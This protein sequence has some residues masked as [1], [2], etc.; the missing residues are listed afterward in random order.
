MKAIAWDC[1]GMG[2]GLG[3]D[4]MLFLANLIRS[5]KSQV[6]FVSEIKSSKVHSVDLVNRFDVAKNFVV[7]S[8]GASGGLWLMWNDDLKISVHSSSF[9]FILANVVHLASGVHFCLICIYGDPYHRQTSAIWNQVSTFVYDNLGKPMICMGDLNDILYDTDGCNGS[10]NYFRMSAFRSIVKNCGFFDIGFS[11]PAYTWRNRQH[12]VNPIYR[13]LDRCLVNADW[14]AHYPNTKVLNL[15]I[16]VSDH[17]PILIST[18]GSFVKPK[19]TFKFENWWL[20]EKDFSS[21]AKSAWNNARAGSFVAKTS[22]LAGALKTWCRKKKPFQQELQ[23]LESSIKQI[24]ELPINQQDHALENSLILRYEQTLSKLNSF[25]KQRSKKGWA[26]DGD[27]NTNFFHQV[28]LKRRKRNTICSVKDEN[29]IVHFKPSL[30]ANTFVNYFRYIFSST[31]INCGRPF[32]ASQLPEGSLDPTYLIPD[33]NEV[34]QIL[35]DM[36]LNASPGPD[37]FNVEF[38]LATWD[39]I[40]DDV[41]QLVVNFYRTG[42]LPSH[43]SDT[44]IALIPKKTCSSGSYGLSSH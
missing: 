5:T 36:K 30:I 27:R 34:L 41:T 43:V 13:R 10:V 20:M 37:G 33:K 1:R 28:V 21:F 11:G 24:Q 42:I 16:I 9:H 35:K 40:G 39:W 29:N 32:L 25:Y 3:S 8:R 44:N 31:H 6:I 18:D 19:Q 12:T 22:S 14:C 2:R 26:T 4:R 23:E 7:P 15:P 17:A 38:Y